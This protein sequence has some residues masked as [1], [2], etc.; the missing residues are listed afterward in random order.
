MPLCTW[1]YCS[2]F[3]SFDSSWIGSLDSSGSATTSNGSAIEEAGDLV[4][5]DLAETRSPS[6]FYPL[7][8]E[9]E[10]SC[11]FIADV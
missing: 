2:I 10:D 11:C 5:T 8:F 4:M 9:S 7:P 1:D 3:G 6:L